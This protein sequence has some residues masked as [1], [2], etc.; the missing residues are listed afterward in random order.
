MRAISDTIRDGEPLFWEPVDANQMHP[1]PPTD[2]RE[3]RAVWVDRPLPTLPGGNDVADAV[4][5]RRG[6]VVALLQLPFQ[7][8]VTDFPHDVGARS[9][10][11]RTIRRETGR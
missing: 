2:R 7:S 6:P 5:C 9:G 10:R 4:G 11:G 3:G 8:R 1:V